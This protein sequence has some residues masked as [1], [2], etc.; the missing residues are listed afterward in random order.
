M[1]K[2]D[3]YEILGVT[4]SSSEDDIKPKQIIGYCPD[5]SI[6]TKYY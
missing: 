5:R 3:Y 2:E 1:S 6:Y 4:N